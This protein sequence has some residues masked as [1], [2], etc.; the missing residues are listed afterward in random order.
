MR[1]ILNFG[2]WTLVWLGSSFANEAVFSTI[3]PNKMKTT[4]ICN[5][6]QY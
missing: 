3:F 4:A 1:R 6:L 2:L 5:D